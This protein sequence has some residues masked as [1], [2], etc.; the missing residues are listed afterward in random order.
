MHKGQSQT[1]SSL[2]HPPLLYGQYFNRGF[3]QGRMIMVTQ[4]ASEH[5]RKEL[6]KKL[7]EQLNES[8]KDSS[9]KNVLTIP[10]K[11]VSTSL[12]AALPDFFSFY[13]LFYFFS[14]DLCIWPSLSP[15]YTQDSQCIL[16]LSISYLG[17]MCAPL[18]VA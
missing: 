9:H 4:K 14:F 18:L 6:G 2:P 13:F 16:P 5:H 17:H 10:H 1:C 11:A 7:F 12:I 15:Q 3:R 8:F